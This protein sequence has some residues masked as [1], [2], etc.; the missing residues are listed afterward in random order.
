MTITQL[1]IGIIGAYAAVGLLFAPLFVARGVARVDSSAEG[2]SL[3][4]RL[5]ILPGVVALW[6]LLA[7][8]WAR[9]AN[10]TPTENNAH[11]RAARTGPT[12]VQEAQR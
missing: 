5:V 7:A 3:G 9:G 8:R 1:I 2:A 11:L 6:P 4:F 10:E 12:S